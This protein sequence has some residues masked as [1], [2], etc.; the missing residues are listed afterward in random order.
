MYQMQLLQNMVVD[1]EIIYSFIKKSQLKGMNCCAAACSTGN[2]R[3][4]I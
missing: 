3:S 4:R 1:L 2:C